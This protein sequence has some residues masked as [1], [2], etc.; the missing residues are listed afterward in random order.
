MRINRHTEL[1]V[2]KKGFSAAME[3]FRESRAFPAEER[4][5]LTDQVRRSSWAIGANLAEAWAK[6][7]YPA[8][9]LSKLTDADGEL[10]ETL[11]WL[12]TSGF[13]MVAP[14][15]RGRRC[16]WQQAFGAK[17]LSGQVSVRVLRLVLN[18]APLREPPQH[19]TQIGVGLDGN[20]VIQTLH[21]QIHPDLCRQRTQ[22]LYGGL[23][24]TGQILTRGGTLAFLRLDPAQMQQVADGGSGGGA[25]GEHGRGR[26]PCAGD[27]VKRCARPRPPPGTT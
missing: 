20:R 27:R 8:H 23:H 19:A 2:F 4:Y 9:F 25:E 12:R 24:Q 5:S 15:C 26:R 18:A 1:E 14:R 13:G 16:N 11:H 22:I 10:Q 21:H 17:A 6:R 3:I 7:R